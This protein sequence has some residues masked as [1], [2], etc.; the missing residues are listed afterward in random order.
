M[1]KDSLYSSVC[2]CISSKIRSKKKIFLLKFAFHSLGNKKKA[3]EWQGLSA[4]VS[5]LLR[6][7]TKETLNGS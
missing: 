3:S 1:Y 7:Q 2:F 4:L 5:V 6:T